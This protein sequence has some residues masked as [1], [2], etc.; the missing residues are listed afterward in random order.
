MK[1]PYKRTVYKRRKLARPRRYI[2][3]RTYKRKKLNTY[4]SPNG[5]FVRYIYKGTTQPKL[6]SSAGEANYLAQPS[7]NKLLD[8]TS[9]F[10]TADPDMMWYFRNYD[11][12]KVSW[13]QQLYVPTCRLPPNSGYGPEP[14]TNN[15]LNTQPEIMVLK[16][17]DG[18][19]RA[20]ET[21]FG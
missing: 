1:K 20:D 7:I 5:D 19:L 3:R 6:I 13:M 21:Y 18:P 11:K 12:Y 9:Q 14:N 8:G 16:E 17:L 15:Y 10:G 4:T 2:K